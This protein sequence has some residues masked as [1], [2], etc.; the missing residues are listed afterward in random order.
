MFA[1]FHQK[2]TIV[3]IAVFSLKIKCQC[4]TL[5]F[6]ADV[7]C[8]SRWLQCISSRLLHPH[9]C[10]CCTVTNII[11]FTAVFLAYARV[12]HSAGG[13]PQQF[14]PLLTHPPISILTLSCPSSP[15]NSMSLQPS[16]PL[17]VTHVPAIS[18]GG[19][20]FPMSDTDTLC[21]LSLSRVLVRI[22]NL[23]VQSVNLA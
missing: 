7:P 19:S 16:S 11:R 4:L 20:H 17:T 18:T 8:L 23:G 22:C 1:V 3:G 6:L 10:T 9:N 15:P 2:L 21:T 14:L 5:D 13:S 12:A